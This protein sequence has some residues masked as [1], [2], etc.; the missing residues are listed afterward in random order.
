MEIADRARTAP[1][2]AYTAAE[3]ASRET[4]AGLAV[5]EKP[6]GREMPNLQE[7]ELRSTA[8]PEVARS[9]HPPRR[10]PPETGRLSFL[11]KLV[12]SRVL[13][14]STASAVVDGRSRDPFLDNAKFL[15][16]VLVAVGHSWGPVVEAVPAVKPLYLFVYAFHMPLFVT[17]CGYFSRNFQG[18]P[19]QVRRL[20]AG[21][22]L[23]YLAF[24]A[25]YSAMYV[26]C[27]GEEFAW[28][29]TSP[30]YLCWFL[31]GLFLWR[32]TA[33]LWSAVRFPLAFAVA[34][35]LV[36]G[37]TDVGSEL[38]LCKVLMFLPWFVLGL[39]LR[40]AQL[41]PLR[42]RAS[43]RWALPVLVGALVGAYWAA[44]RVTTQWLLMQ[45]SYE[46]LGVAPEVYLGMRVAL[47]AVGL[48]LCAAFL[49]AVP[50][51][52]TRFTAFGARTMYPF[53]LHGLLIK[54]FEGLGG[55]ELVVEWGTLAMVPVTLLAG[56]AAVGLSTAPVCRCLRPLVE[57]RLPGFLTPR[58]RT[59]TQ[60]TGTGAGAP[61]SAAGANVG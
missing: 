2:T 10:K 9:V 54:A 15:L 47:F 29:P 50:A 52:H 49:A 34:I 21:V 51:V 45:Q 12:P 53:L 33:P 32:L 19:D 41:R 44:P 43:R 55:Y 37:L 3:Q 40:S 8:S 17:L 46:Q 1:R 11:A 36:A 23:P 56:T 6:E 5:Q 24:E 61:S 16:V 57:P 31:V 20:V 48:V 13:S 22:L 60:Q 42:N 7:A 28:T 59:S 35:S 58:P 26:V 27:F 39:R 4:A 25:I 14:G 18:R 38:A 30:R